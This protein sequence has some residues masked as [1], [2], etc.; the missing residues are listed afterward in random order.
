MQEFE[1]ELNDI[2][3]DEEYEKLIEKLTGDNIIK[4]GSNIKSLH[5]FEQAMKSVI[6][7]TPK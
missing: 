5:S 3:E 4:D 1:Q 7:S 6:D 2:I